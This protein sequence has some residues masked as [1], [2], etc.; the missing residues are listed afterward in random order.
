MKKVISS[1]LIQSCIVAKL[2][3]CMMLLAHS[4]TFSR[5]PE[6]L[7]IGSKAPEFD[8]PATDGKRYTL[9]DFKGKKC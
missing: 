7:A 3:V 2:T 5:D 9:D 4:T 6:P 1:T 8:L